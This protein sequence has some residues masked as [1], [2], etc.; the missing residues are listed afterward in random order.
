MGDFDKVQTLFGN[1]LFEL[2]RGSAGLRVG[3][4]LVKSAGALEVCVVGVFLSCG[5]KML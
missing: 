1:P 5:I 4:Q 2:K 3:I